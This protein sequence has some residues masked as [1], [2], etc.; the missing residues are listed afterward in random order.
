MV[1]TASRERCSITAKRQRVEVFGHAV[2]GEFQLEQ[3]LKSP[4]GQ[5]LA[6]L[7]GSVGH[8]VSLPSGTLVCGAGSDKKTDGRC[9]RGSAQ[10]AQDVGDAAE[11]VPVRTVVSESL[12]V[13][14]VALG[15]F[16]GARWRGWAC[17]RR[18][19]R[20]SSR[21]GARPE[22]SWH[23]RKW[24]PDGDQDLGLGLGPASRRF[25][26]QIE[27]ICDPAAWAGPDGRALG[28]GPGMW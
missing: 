10:R 22:L 3:G 16:A 15:R 8:G 18:S 13:L 24:L 5:C 7:W 9:G 1:Q 6:W 27:G 21:T 26:R 19:V 25:L 11:A 17:H 14:D 28:H 23:G 12:D 4:A 2:L 20:R